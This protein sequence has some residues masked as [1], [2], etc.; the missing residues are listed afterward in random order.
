MSTQI[1]SQ[2]WA[3]KGFDNLH[4]W[5]TQKRDYLKEY[6]KRCLVKALE[7]D[8][9]NVDA[10]YA[11]GQYYHFAGNPGLASRC[12]QV[13]ERVKQFRSERDGR[14]TLIEVKAADKISA[15]TPAVEQF[16]IIWWDVVQRDAEHIAETIPTLHP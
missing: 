7:C 1:S 6:S 16:V 10:W 11:L 12:E 4:T 3:E 8:P 14:A 15:T 5:V 9:T 2:Q 13:K